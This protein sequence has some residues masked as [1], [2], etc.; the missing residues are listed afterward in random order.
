MIIRGGFS[1]SRPNG[2]LV[3]MLSFLPTGNLGADIEPGAPEVA[4]GTDQT[5]ELG[6]ILVGE[7]L[8]LPLRVVNCGLRNVRLTGAAVSGD[9]A[10]VQSVQ[11][12]PMTLGSGEVAVARVLLNPSAEG[13]SPRVT[14]Q[15]EN[16]ALG[17]IT[18]TLHYTATLSRRA[19]T[20]SA[21]SA[22]LTLLGERLSIRPTIDGTRPYTCHWFKDGRA[23]ASQTEATLDVP[24][25]RAEDAGIYRLEVRWPGG[26]VRLPEEIRIGIYQN[27]FGLERVLDADNLTLPARA[28]GPGVSFQWSVN[29]SWAITGTRSARLH[30][31]RADVLLLA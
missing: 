9:A 24:R 8:D 31:K 11:L 26:K 27:L 20:I 23:L 10:G 16:A 7:T 15:H 18:Y 5:I 29:E 28:W 14:I 30:A 19:V 2:A 3:S 13:S 22:S 21:P 25:A 6:E 12:D 4:L 17:E 1:V